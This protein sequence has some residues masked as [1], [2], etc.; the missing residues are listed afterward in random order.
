MKGF[1]QTNILTTALGLAEPL[2][3]PNVEMLLSEKDPEKIASVND[4]FK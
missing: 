2:R 4:F 3:V 1:S